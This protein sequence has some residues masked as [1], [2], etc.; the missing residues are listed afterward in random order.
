MSRVILR[1]GRVAELREAR[2]NEQDRALIR[3]LFSKA[4]QESL[5]FRFFSAVR[6]VSDEMIENM[7]GDGGRNGLLLLCLSGEKALGIGSYTR[8]DDETAEVA[9]LVEDSLHGKGIGTLL[10]EHLAQTAWRHGFKRFKAFVLGD[11]YKMLHV[12]Q[13]SGYTMNSERESGV[14]H[15]VL[16]LVETERTRALQATREK[17]ATAA[18]LL[19][20]FRPKTVA[21][22]GASPEAQGLDYRMV[23][24]L[25]GGG[26]RGTVYPVHPHVHAVAAV[27][28]YPRLADLP[29]KIDLAILVVPSAQILPVIHDC[30]EAG[31]R[32]VMIASAGFAEVNREGSE[33]QQEVVRLLRG[34]GCRL[35]GPNCLGI[36]NT[37]EEFQL[38]A[39]F[40]PRLPIRGPLA[41]ASQSGALGMAIIDY[42]CRMGLGI[43]N[44]V[45]MGNK[46]DVSSND[47]LQYWEDD[48]ETRMIVLYLESFGNPRKFSRIARRITRQKPILAVKS[49][50][51]PVGSAISEARTAAMLARDSV[52]EALFRQ[53]GIVR[54]DTLQELFDVAALLAVAPLPAGRRVAIVTNSAGGAVMTVD[55]L[56]REGLELVEPVIDLGFEALAEKYRE[57]LPQVMR[58][59]SVDAVIVLFIS[60]GLPEEKEVSQ[61][62]A[63]AVQEVAREKGEAERAGLC[64]PVV[65]IFLAQREY[66]VRYLAAGEQRIPV[67][68]FPEQAVHALSKMITYADYRRQARG[69]IPDLPRID[70]ERARSLVRQVLHGSRT[71]LLR[72][73]TAAVLAAVGLEVEGERKA[74]ANRQQGGRRLLIEVEPDVLFGPLI[75]LRLLYG[76]RDQLPEGEWIPVRSC[77]RILPL[78][79]LDAREMAVTVFERRT[80][81]TTGEELQ[82]KG[83]EDGLREEFPTVHKL[84]ECLLRLSRL[85]ED[86]PEIMRLR[87]SLELT[88]EA[89]RIADCS[90]EAAMEE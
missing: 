34:T 79:D 18:S 80:E 52:V 75:Y 82:E 7:L 32:A 81:G 30:M 73:Q 37:A 87:L 58:D 65:A 25:L 59:S 71:C 2:H 13:N 22:V 50:R 62:I 56:L 14:I 68:P 3:E 31:V 46:A 36:I 28:A 29:E 55:A 42:A 27:R 54:V 88:P 39:S 51:T 45:S 84:E 17:L 1:D 35:I 38:N 4:S 49:A 90:L 9:L 15:L 24:H 70:G 77:V 48:P 20:F 57:V 6:E 23:R 89:F 63:E 66:V 53:T 83:K 60:A 26:F 40:V 44:F 19:P 78:T 41:I 8:V 61:A 76:T 69:R 21:V 67:Y 16:P 12:F 64:K 72:E 47:L 74:G 10:L 11:N 5:Y 33:L 86:V 43:S 85:I